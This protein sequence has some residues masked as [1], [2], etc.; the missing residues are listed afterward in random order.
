M[1]E[2]EEEFED[3][4]QISS[5]K[6]KYGYNLDSNYKIKYKTYSITYRKTNYKFAGKY[7]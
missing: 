1:S 4:N 3:N 2:Y 7:L 6:E 5:L